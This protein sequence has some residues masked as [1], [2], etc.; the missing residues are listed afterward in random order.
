MRSV[1][2]LHDSRIEL[3]EVVFS[4]GSVPR[5]FN[6]DKSVIWFVVRQSPASKGV[7][8]EFEEDTAME[9]VTRRQPVKIQQTEKTSCVL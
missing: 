6:Q 2:Q 3:L 8:T 9:A 4:V 5:C 1:R 7:N